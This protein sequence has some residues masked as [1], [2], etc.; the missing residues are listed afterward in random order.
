MAER[1]RRIIAATFQGY[2]LLEEIESF[3]PVNTEK[4]MEASRGGRFVGRELM[5]G[6]ENM[7]AS[8][9]LNGADSAL[10]GDLSPAA[11]E[12]VELYVREAW[13]T[14]DG[15]AIS[16]KHEITGTVNNVESRETKMGE[17]PQ[18]TVS[19]AVIASKRTEGDTLIHNINVRTQVVD[20]GSGDLMEAHRRA[21]EV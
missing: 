2:P 18:R 16:V 14:E 21:A 8:I 20:L 6:L 3:T 13:E 4:T 1:T 9:V 11:G 15:E 17:F 5:V 19:I 12:D 10:F 7:T